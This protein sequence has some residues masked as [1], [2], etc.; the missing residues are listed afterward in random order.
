MQTIRLETRIAAPIERCF[1]L[2]RD[3]DTHIRSASGTNERAI[4]QRRHGLLQLGD[5]VTWEATHFGVPMR[6][7]VRITAVDR[8]RVFEDTMVSGPFRSLHHRHEF[9][10]A[11]PA[12]TSMR[13]VFT[14]AA[15]YG[16]VGGAVER[17]LLRP[18]LSRFLKRRADVLRHMAEAAG[19]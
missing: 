8:P 18:Y 1:D 17:L 2:A 11:D 10:A 12:G 6:M 14:F 16:I 19:A 3:I 13:D 15:P 7:T 5:E 4:G 9:A